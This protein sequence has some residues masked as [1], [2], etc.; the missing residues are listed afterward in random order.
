M[1][2]II[3]LLS[4]IITLITAQDLQKT[5]QSTVTI[6]SEE[7]NN[8]GILL[9]TEEKGSTFKAS[10]GLA[11]RKSKEEIHTDDLFEIGSASKMFTAIAIFQLIEQGKLSLDTSLGKLYPK[12]KIRALANF[13]GKNYWD[14]VTVGMLL[15]HT[16]G[17]IDYLNVYGDDAKAIEIYSD[18]SKVYTFDT[19]IDLALNFG[20]ANFKPGTAFKY[21]NTGYI[22][23]GDIISKVSGMNWHDFIEK[24][25]FDKAGVKRTYFGTRLPEGIR[26]KMPKG[27][28][29][30]KLTSMPMALA[31][32]AGE[33]VSNL[34]DLTRLIDTW[35]EGG[36]YK[37]DETLQIQKTQG[38]HR[39]DPAITNMN[40][41]YGL[42]EIDGYYG[43]G[44]QTFGFE[45]YVTTNPDN[46][47]TYIVGTNDAMVRSM[48]LFMK[49]AGI[50][51]KYFPEH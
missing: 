47:N 43:H 8:T 27:Y 31:D 48:A 11:D 6:Y 50:E 3:I 19:I 44:G 33:I 39:M 42:M 26:K 20:D 32:S 25:I 22:I 15:N 2:K 23:L 49:M 51:Y 41:G 38:Y 17:F 10:A 37:K 35:K 4:T 18:K 45:S 29:F 16:S 5:V 12:G 13:K 46:N 14:D 30:G 9:L 1:K 28:I 34:D 40:Y 21:C 24:H 36:Y 7:S